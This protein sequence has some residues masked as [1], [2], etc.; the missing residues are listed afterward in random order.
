MSFTKDKLASLRGLLPMET[1]V[2]VPEMKRFSLNRESTAL[3]G[4]TPL[5]L[6]RICPRLILSKQSTAR[7][8][9]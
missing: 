7:L 1:L 9:R 4:E 2:A 8:A 5:Q 3:G 6:V